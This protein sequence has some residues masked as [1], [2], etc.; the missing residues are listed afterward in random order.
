MSISEERRARDAE[1]VDKTKVRV[2]KALSLKDQGYSNVKIAEELGIP[3]GA[4]RT[5]LN[6]PVEFGGRK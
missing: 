1:A 4:V 3:E 5:L 2:A 6:A